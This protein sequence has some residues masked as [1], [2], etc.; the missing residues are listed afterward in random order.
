MGSG[1][2]CG[3]GK[4]VKETATDIVPEIIEETSPLESLS[5]STSSSPCNG[6][7][8]MSIYC[9]SICSTMTPPSPES[10]AWFDE[11]CG[12]WWRTPI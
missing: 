1:A 12:T 2:A 10:A 8:S 9:G 3:F 4:A 11:V 5:S 7:P 6:T